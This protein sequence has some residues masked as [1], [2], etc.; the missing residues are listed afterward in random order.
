MNGQIWRRHAELLLS[1]GRS[2][3]PPTRPEPVENVGD[4]LPE[5]PVALPPE[6]AANPENLPEDPPALVEETYPVAT[7]GDTGAEE[8]SADSPP[9]PKVYPRRERHPPTRYEPSFN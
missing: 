7:R 1:Q 3:Y 9:S 8:P 5:V 6:V 2:A 4:E